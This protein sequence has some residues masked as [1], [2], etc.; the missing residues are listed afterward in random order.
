[1]FS[2]VFTGPLPV[3]APRPPLRRIHLAALI[4]I[5]AAPPLALPSTAADAADM[6]VKTPAAKTYNWG[7]C[8]V[9]LN[10]G[11]AESGSDFTTTV[12]PG[13]HLGAG[14]RRAGRG[15]RHLVG[16]RSQFP[17]RR[18]GRLQLAIR[19]ARLW[20]RRRRRLLPQQS[21]SHQRHG[22][23]ERRGHQLHRH[24]VAD[25][26][27]PRHGASAPRR[28][29]RP[30][31]VLHH[32]R[33]RLHQGELFAGLCGCR[34][35]LRHR[36]RN[37]LEIARRL[38]RRRRMGIRLDRQLDPQV[39]VPVHELPGHHQRD[40][41]DHRRRG[42]NQSAPGLGESRRSRPPASASTSNSDRAIMLEI[43]SSAFTFIARPQA[44]RRPAASRGANPIG[45]TMSTT[46]DPANAAAPPCAPAKRLRLHAPSWPRSSWR[47]CRC[48]A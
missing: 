43:A 33:R 7:G 3:R 37:R 29:G 8:Y 40:R 5:A 20:P 31:P 18:P 13:T 45:A 35:P 6:P 42:R 17:R 41:R 25:D 44:R 27:F 1:M 4:A 26:Q 21:A 19:D 36:P 30:Q 14:R 39:R 32:R 46:T 23:A 24:P 16:Q 9:G 15:G 11:G 10:G 34:R 28:L 38:D 2:Q 47:W 48:S 22:D 12:G